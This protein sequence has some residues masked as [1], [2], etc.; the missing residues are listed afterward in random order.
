MVGPNYPAIGNL[1]M[2][3]I[4]IITAVIA[5]LFAASG[6]AS[7]KLLELE[8]FTWGLPL[9][10]IE[11]RAEDHNFR[12]REKE[13]SLPEP[14]LEYDAFLRGLNCRVGF[15]FTPLGGKL[16][17]VTATWEGPEFAE[18]LKEELVKE[19]GQ[20]REEIPG[21]RISIWTRR[22]TELTLRAGR[23]Q[24]TLTYCHLLLK[25]E[26]REEADLIRE[27]PVKRSVIPE[28]YRGGSREDREPSP[29]P[30]RS[31]NSPTPFGGGQ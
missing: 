30:P 24:T 20:P 1:T 29:I 4:H 5:L 18:T 11:R 28:S 10:E 12:L 17:Q 7:A 2:K 19:Y 13:I 15:F 26:A 16:Y 31:S 9:G 6:T 23:G 21:A 3:Y 27:E 8:N 14:L 25:R 22:I